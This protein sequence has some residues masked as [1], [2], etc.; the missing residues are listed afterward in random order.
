MPNPMGIPR[1]FDHLMRKKHTR[2]SFPPWG[3]LT[4]PRAIRF[5]T[6]CFLRS[7]GS[8]GSGP[9]SALKS[10]GPYHRQQFG[11][12]CGLR[13]LAIHA[14]TR[15]HPGR[16][17]RMQARGLQSCVRA[18]RAFAILPLPLP[19]RELPGLAWSQ[20]FPPARS[21]PP[22]FT[23][24]TNDVV[25]APT[26]TRRIPPSCLPCPISPPPAT[27]KGQPVLAPSL[28]DSPSSTSW[29]RRPPGS[30]GFDFMVEETFQ[31]SK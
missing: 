2:P 22:L 31:A 26:R 16:C 6:F 17:R 1:N 10:N 5:A 11:A 9:L 7:R 19:S 8:S 21:P 14:K 24:S 28:V 27:E 15:V 20:A 3:H 4:W 23:A 13:F 12:A 25:V 18:V 29:W 30:G